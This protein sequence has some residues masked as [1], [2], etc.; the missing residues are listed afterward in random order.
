M[1]PRMQILLSAFTDEMEKISMRE[2]PARATGVMPT[3]APPSSPSGRMQ[4]LRESA[5]LRK[6]RGKMS[7]GPLGGYTRGGGRVL[8]K[9]TP[10]L[11]SAMTADAGKKLL[12][13]MTRGKA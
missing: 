11:G 2:L 3:G 13:F 7:A 10:G 8:P 5:Q 4:Q 6:R 12:G 1:D 9:K